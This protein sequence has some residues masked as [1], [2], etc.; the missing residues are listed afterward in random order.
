M[1]EADKHKNIEGQCPKCGNKDTVNF[2]NIQNYK[3]FAC[4]NPKKPRVGCGLQFYEEI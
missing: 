1:T 2:F 3:V 4:Q